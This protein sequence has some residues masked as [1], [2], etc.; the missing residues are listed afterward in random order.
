MRS[1]DCFD[2]PSHIPYAFVVGLEYKMHI[3]NI[4][5]DYSKVYACNGVKISK[6]QTNKKFQTGGRAFGAPA[7]DPPLCIACLNDLSL[8]SMTPRL[9]KKI[10][11]QHLLLFQ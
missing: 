1:E 3:V 10:Y 4:A 2:A 7:L 6:K 8:L 5:F 9:S 11:K